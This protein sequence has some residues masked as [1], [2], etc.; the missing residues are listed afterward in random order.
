MSAVLTSILVDVAAKVGA[1]L[2]KGIL[3]KH[4][5]G[6]AGEVG[7]VVIDAI[8]EKAG[9]A[10]EKL[11]DVPVK[12]LEAAVAQVETDAPEIIRAYT[13]SQ[14]ETNRLQ[15]AEM[16]KE[17]NFGWMWR[18]AGMWLMLVCVAW[19]VI[20]VPLLNAVLAAIG[21]RTTVALI[22]D[23]A[24]FVTVFMTYCTLYMGGNTVLRSFIKK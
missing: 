17:N 6:T 21:A 9:V 18:P 13:E 3:E 20:L 10:P 23:F 5:G 12:D 2:I 4:V 7:G 1:P 19:Y 22:V 11:Q 14:R 24:S 8:A 16:S 15:L